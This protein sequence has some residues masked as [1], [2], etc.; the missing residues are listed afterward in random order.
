MEGLREFNASTVA[1]DR[2]WEYH[3]QSSSLTR[4]VV[5]EDEIASHYPTIPVLK[6]GAIWTDQPR[7]SG[8]IY[9][10]C[11]LTSHVQ[12]SRLGDT[13]TVT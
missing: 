6:T 2:S 3:L 1:L 10:P 7:T 5:A 8:S 4:N 13:V 12:I 9:I 11:G